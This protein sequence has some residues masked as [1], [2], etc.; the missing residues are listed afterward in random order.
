MEQSSGA[1][2]NES[3]YISCM[4]EARSQYLRLRFRGRGNDLLECPR[5]G[6]GELPAGLIC[7]PHI[8]ELDHPIP[9]ACNTYAHALTLVLHPLIEYVHRTDQAVLPDK[10]C[11]MQT[12]DV[13]N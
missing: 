8:P 4:H 7:L 12:D 13:K 11:S 2:H 9:G 1:N 5:G 3:A 10:C 6:G